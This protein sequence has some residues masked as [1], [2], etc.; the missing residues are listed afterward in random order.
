MEGI[1]C[2]C[3]TLSVGH[4][5]ARSSP[6]AIAVIRQDRPEALVNALT[7]PEL[8]ML[9]NGLPPP[10]LTLPDF[11]DSSAAV[12]SDVFDGAFL[13]VDVECDVECVAVADVVLVVMNV[14]GTNV[15]GTELCVAVFMTIVPDEESVSSP[16]DGPGFDG[17][18]IVLCPIVAVADGIGPPAVTTAT[19]QST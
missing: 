4:L 12:M 2:R 14:V 13:E 19:L 15:V 16:L 6:E 3:R 8:L 1:H 9:S 5:S 10:D 17:T 7:A 11:I 18:T